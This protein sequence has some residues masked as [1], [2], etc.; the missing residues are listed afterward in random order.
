MLGSSGVGKT[1][2]MAAIYER[3]NI[4]LQNTQ[5]EFIASSD[6]KPRLEACLQELKDLSNKNHFRT[7]GGVSGTQDPALFLFNLGKRGSNKSSID[8][9][10]QDFPGGYHNHRTEYLKKSL[11]ECNAVLIAIDA[12]AMMEEKGKWHEEI[13]RTQQMLELFE[14]TYQQLD[15]PKLIMLVPIK[16]ETY[17]TDLKSQDN[18][19][20][21]IAERYQ[22]L[23]KFF[24]SPSLSG[25]VNVVIT[26]VETVGTVVFGRIQEVQGEPQ[27]FYCKRNSSLDD[28]NPQGGEEVL[29]HLLRFLLAS[30]IEQKKLLFGFNWI[31]NLLNRDTEFHDAI[32]KLTV[33][34]HSDR[35]VPIIETALLAASK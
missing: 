1:S 19:S 4:V 15:L 6:T 8:F 28:Y 5:L 7:N 23:I 17:M 25:K 18:L 9:T 11:M 16:C 35:S 14:Q 33:E 26:P 2:L 32:K 27:F 24:R 22:N 20:Q 34:S 30:H 31:Y 10:F 3:S 21:T 29:R 13:N 12:T